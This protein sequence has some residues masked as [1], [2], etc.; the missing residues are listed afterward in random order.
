LQENGE[1]GC[2]SGES[3]FNDERENDRLWIA[4]RRSKFDLL[5]SGEMD[6]AG[7][8]LFNDGRHRIPLYAKFTKKQG[9]RAE[10]T[11]IL[12]HLARGD[13]DFRKQQASALRE[14]ARIK[15]DPMIAIGDYNFDYEFSTPKRNS[16]FD[17]FVRDGGWKWIKP[18]EMID[19]NW[20][21]DGNGN[22]VY[23]GSMLDFNF[24]VG[25]AKEWQTECRVIVRDRGF[26][27]NDNTSDHRPVELILAH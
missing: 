27:D 1:F 2:V 11:I 12:N 23:P 24:V 4:C 13:E 10:F 16:G 20:H 3:G 6:E 14:W 8:F 15:S 17:E 26:P 9:K 19:T 18:F 22:D 21:D 5:E 25:Q 7:G